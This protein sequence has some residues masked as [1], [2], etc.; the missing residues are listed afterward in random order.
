MPPA[1]RV[2]LRM[3]GAVL[4]GYAFSATGAA[5]LAVVLSHFTPMHRGEAVLLAAMLGFM[6]YLAVLLWAFSE[7]R[8]AKV[9]LAMFGGACLAHGAALL[10]A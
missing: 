1:L 10:L 5:F 3:V 2:A 6:L 9:W 8:L 7:R 4:G